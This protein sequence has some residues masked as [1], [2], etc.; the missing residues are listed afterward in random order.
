MEK[1]NLSQIVGRVFHNKNANFLDFYNY[2]T[3]KLFFSLNYSMTVNNRHEMVDQR[4]YRKKQK[5][6]K[7]F[8]IYDIL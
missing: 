3:R 1:K 5:L 2:D 6:T 4:F 8:I 7:F